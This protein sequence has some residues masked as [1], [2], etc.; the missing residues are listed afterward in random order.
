MK[1]KKVFLNGQLVPVTEATISIFDRGLTYGDGVFESLRT[2]RGTPFQLEEHIK[3]LLRELKQLRINLP[4]SAAQ[5]KLAVLRTVF[6]NNFK[7][8]YIKIIITRGEAKGHG[9]DPSNAAGRPTAIVSVEELKPYP[10]SLFK[11]GWKAIISSIARPDV[12]TSRIKSLGYLN[13]IL[14]KMEAKK[15]GANEA[16]LLDARGNLA[17]G[18]ISNIFIIKNGLIYTP[19]IEAPILPGLTRS[20]II[21]LAQRSAYK[22]VEKYLPPKELYAADECF[23]TLSGPGIVPITKIWGK[24]IGSGKCGQITG[25]LIKIFDA[26]TMQP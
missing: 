13:N 7:E 5:L 10:K 22:V 18:T 25:S 17:E 20:L 4:L 23:I 15:A 9:L 1:S 11:N 12:P 24:K 2:Y 26:E 3:R 6:A 16:F 8:S 19:P 21:H 14:A